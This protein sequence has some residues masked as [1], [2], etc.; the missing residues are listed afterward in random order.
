MR[1]ILKNITIP[2]T[3]EQNL[4]KAILGRIK[5]TS[6]LPQDITIIR[7]ALDTRK[8]DSPVYVYTVEIHTVRK[9]PNYPDVMPYVEPDKEMLPSVKLSDLQPFII[10]MGPAGLFCALAMVKNGLKP[11]VFDRGNKLEKRAEAVNLF[12]EKGVLNPQCNVQFGEGGAGAFSDGKLTSRISNESVNAVYDFLIFYGA[13]ED[14]KWE[15][16]PHLGTDTIRTVVG[17]IRDYLITQGCT[18]HYNSQLDDISIQNDTVKEI[19][20]NG[21]AYQPEVLV[22]APG[23]AARDTFRLL[24]DKHVI[25]EPKPFAVGFRINH[26]QDWINRS[27]YGNELWADR[28]GAASYRLT[29]NKSGSGTYTFC[30]CPG[31]YIIAAS[32]EPGSIVT[33]GMSYTKRENAFGNSAVVT[34]VNAMDYGDKLF[35]GMEF[36]AVIEKRAF[37][38]DYSAPFQT[39]EDYLK[40]SL[41]KQQN[42]NCQFPS[43]TPFMISKL[44]PTHLDKALQDALVHF[45][46]VLPGFINQGILIAPE[47][48]T[49]SPIR[50]VR[51]KINLN[52]ININNLYAAGEG[53]GYAGGIV[54]S[55]ADGYRIG[56][57]FRV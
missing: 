36:Q 23:N 38:D 6:I 28:L 33:N 16:L 25:L 49:S 9:I 30:M 32:S 47:T 34:S 55:S 15:A 3:T 37:L 31:G 12:W 10:G 40:S 19:R 29:S 57:L 14:I 24:S 35:D 20:I 21:I 53:S 7:R 2:A 13:P 5:R 56:S 43:S 54:S 11:I 44:F 1:Y 45:D 4:A 22:L 48:R 39:A 8:K 17:R 51:D 27:I 41:S 50:M 26:S 42:I 46:K 52:C 18:F